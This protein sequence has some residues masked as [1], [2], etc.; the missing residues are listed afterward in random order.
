[1]AVKQ[2][3]FLSHAFCPVHP[4]SLKL[5]QVTN[6]DGMNMDALQATTAAASLRLTIFSGR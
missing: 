1:L 2:E 6:H 3:H 5:Q 4:K